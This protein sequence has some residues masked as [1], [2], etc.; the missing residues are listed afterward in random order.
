M[1][2]N[3]IRNYGEFYNEHLLKDD[4]RISPNIEAIVLPF[5]VYRKTRNSFYAENS[6]LHRISIYRSMMT[7][8]VL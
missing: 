1:S 4:Q 6:G 3:I 8:L 7:S 2:F 5:M